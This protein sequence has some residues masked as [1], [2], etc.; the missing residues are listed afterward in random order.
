MTVAKITKDANKE[1]DCK[2]DKFVFAK[3]ILYYNFLIFNK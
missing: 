1:L 3:I 2:L